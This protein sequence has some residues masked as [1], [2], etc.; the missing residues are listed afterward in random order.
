LEKINKGKTY[1]IE[2]KYG[3]KENASLYAAGK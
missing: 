3:L 2:P 1:E